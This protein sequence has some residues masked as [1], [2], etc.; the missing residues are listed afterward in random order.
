[1]S[2]AKPLKTISVGVVVERSRAQSQWID[3]VWRPVQVLP[4]APETPAWTRLSEDGDRATFYAGSADIELYRTDTT[5]Y[6]DN[7]ASGS[8][9]LWVVLRPTDSDPPYSLVAVTAD[10]AEGEAFTEAGA[11]LVEMVPMPENIADEVAQFVSEHHVERVFYK[12]KRKQA[13]PEALAQHSPL[14]KGRK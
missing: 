11:D 2:V 3:Y 13:D 1:M 4:A 9:S 5:Q 14:Q 12:R 10:T 7:L 8:P 6:R